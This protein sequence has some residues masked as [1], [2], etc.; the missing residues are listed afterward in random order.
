MFNYHI[1]WYALKVTR[2]VQLINA[3]T[4]NNDEQITF[5]LPLTLQWF[6]KI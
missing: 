3:F 5:T 2:L 1:K 4:I 6:R